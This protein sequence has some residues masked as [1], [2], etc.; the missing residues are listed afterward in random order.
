LS[1][2]T[3]SSDLLFRSAKFAASFLPNF[4]LR[5]ANA[6][7]DGHLELRKVWQLDKRY[8][9]FW[10]RFCGENEA[11]LVERDAAYMHWR[12]HEHPENKYV[13]YVCEKD[14]EIVGFTVLSLERN[15]SLPGAKARELVVGNIVDLFT[16]QDDMHNVVSALISV[17]CNHF[18]NENVDV[19]MC[20]IP[21]WHAYRSIFQ[22]SGFHGYYNLLKR[23]IFRSKCDD[24]QFICYLS[25]RPHIARAFESLPKENK[26][27]WL[28]MQGDADF[29]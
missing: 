17:A 24:G 10:R 25:S 14:D 3:E 9:T 20:W 28:L 8:V 6:K 27:C 7:P 11:I 4:Q 2:K 22:E 21:E 26:P 1:K 12:Y 15:A 5:K 23:A 19:A 29:M 13:M 16:L 18:R